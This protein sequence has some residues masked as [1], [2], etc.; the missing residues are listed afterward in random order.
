MAAEDKL[1]RE[2]TEMHT[3]LHKCALIVDESRAYWQRRASIGRVPS[4]KE[5]FD[6]CW[7]GAKS[8]SWVTLLLLN[9]RTRYDAFPESHQVLQRWSAMTP[10][11]RTVICH[12]HMQLTDPLYRAF[13]GDYL[14]S[15][16]ELANPEIHVNSVVS[17]VKNNG[18]SSWTL[19]T[20]KKLAFRLLSVASSAG[21][22]T[23]RRDPRIPV[24]PRINDEALTYILY[25]LR[26]ISTSGT[27]L[28]NPYLS[29]VGLTGPVL[30]ARL[31]KLP[32]MKFQRVADVVEF[33][34]K[35][36]TITAWAEAELMNYEVAS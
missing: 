10:D 29:S 20:K 12:W 26:D 30:E 8:L 1:Y 16:R 2:A 4:S 7:F 34:W 25:I 5:A 31:R 19:S 23:G 9:L 17:W 35:Y 14:V 22:I 27:R 32:T 6:Q 24:F 21:L 33:N 15:R 28:D 11:T 3:R 13:T 18:Q 36:P